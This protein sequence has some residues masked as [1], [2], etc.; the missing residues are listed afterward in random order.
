LANKK[1]DYLF[2]SAMLRAREA[3]ML[4]RER[5]ERML[6][7]ASYGEAAKMLADCGYKDY[8]DFSVKEVEQAL[9]ERRA[10]SFEEMAR[11][12]PN[13]LLVDVFRMK[14]DYHNAKTLIKSE[15]EGI[16]RSDLMSFA[17]RIPPETLKAAF[18]EDRYNDIA[19]VMGRAVLEAKSALSR[20]GNPQ[21]ADFILDR[22]YFEELT[23]AADELD[24][25]FFTGYV[26]L[27]I[28]SA[29]LRSAV[30]TLRMHK[31]ADFLRTALISGG[32]IEP[33]RIAAAIS[34]EGLTALYSTTM[35]EE[36]ANLGA[37]AISG[38]TMTKFELACDNAVTAY[39]IG[40]HMVAFGEEPVIA[41]LAALEGEITAVRMILTGRLSGIEPD[42]IR[43][44]LRDLYA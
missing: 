18:D 13:E 3:K 27:L 43:E 7:A 23:N 40:S 14:Y 42:V 16:D 29:N 32:S 44:R 9:N 39:L 37:A 19:G 1:E 8:S 33:D 4:T 35:L 31:D 30:R 10:S 5:A 20:T 15:A 21:L 17:G 26:Q 24:S 41:Y 6:D 34:G 38:G 22:A 11:M 2:L 36:A 25:K 28:D 12:A